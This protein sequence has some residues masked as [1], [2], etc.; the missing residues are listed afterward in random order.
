M[1]LVDLH[2]PY[3]LKYVYIRI[4]IYALKK[5][6]VVYILPCIQSFEVTELVSQLAENQG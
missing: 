1:L 3:P 5:Y 2:V 6:N 4:Q